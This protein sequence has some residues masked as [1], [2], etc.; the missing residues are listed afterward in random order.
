ME[1]PYNV[2]NI[3]DFHFV[4][5]QHIIDMFDVKKVQSKAGGLYDVLNGLFIDFSLRPAPYSE[6]PLAF[7]HLYRSQSIFKGKNVIYLADR[8][9]GSAEIISHLECIDYH[10]IIRG[11][12]N[13]YKK[14]VALM[15]S[16]DEWIEVE[17]DEKWRGDSDFHLKP[18][19]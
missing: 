19:N 12:S 1:I 3:Y 5:N 9:Y 11:K 17:I 6:L 8:Y 14:Q 2:Y 13:F 10:Y 15:K 4:E 16:D 7:S 18:W